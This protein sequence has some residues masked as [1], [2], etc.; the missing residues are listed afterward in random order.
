[1]SAGFERIDPTGS[2]DAP[3][4][5][6]KVS[7]LLKRRAHPASYILRA[8]AL[9]ALVL[10]TALNVGFGVAGNR[11]PAELAAAAL[12]SLLL[13]VFVVWICSFWYA[14]RT[15]HRRYVVFLCAAGLLLVVNASGIA[16]LR[17]YNL[18]PNTA[19]E[20][21]SAEDLQERALKCERARDL[22]C[23][24]RTWTQY[25]QLRLEDGRGLAYL[26]MIKSRRD[27]H[28]G[29]ILQFEKAVATG[30]GAYD[31]F[32]FYGASLAK[33]GRTVEGIDWHY[34]AL[35]AAPSLVDVRGSLA[36]LLVSQSRQYEALA[37]LQAFDA[38]A[39]ARGRQPYFT[40]QRIAIE[41]IISDNTEAFT[42]ATALRLPAYNGHFFVP[43]SLGVARPA[44]FMI[45]TGASLTVLNQ[46]MLNS[47]KVVYRLIDPDAHMRTAD[48]RR[49]AAEVVLIDALRVGPYVLRQV[50]AL[51]CRDCATLL[52]QS[53]LSKFDLQSS[54]VDGVEFLTLVP[55]KL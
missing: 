6:A 22:V 44:A 23:A 36:T 51:S 18:L 54:K 3:I 10:L 50:K 39:E 46:A 42:A 8:C 25:T 43:V 7:F 41:K 38:Q 45:D 53:T 19:Q 21:L 32:A 17:G 34:R 29:A 52:G 12:G 14:N 20:T 37:L 11:S 16:L 49:V 30:T 27:D 9:G 40:G 24:E 15:Q 48:G 47:S 31:L 55:R 26:G 35:A 33:V 5:P 4:D 13:P 2:M 28:Q 1:M